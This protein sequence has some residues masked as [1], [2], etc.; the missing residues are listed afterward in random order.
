MGFTRFDDIIGRSDLLETD[1]EVLNGKLKKIDFSPLLALPDTDE[2]TIRKY[3]G[4]HQPH[5]LNGHIDRSLIEA[6]EKAIKGKEKVWL[7]R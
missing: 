5:I 7:F 3:T 4:Q 1:P 6:A 2:K